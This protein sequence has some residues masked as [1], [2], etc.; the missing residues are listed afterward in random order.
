MPKAAKSD[1]ENENFRRARHLSKVKPI[2]AE[3]LREPPLYVKNKSQNNI[4]SAA[5]ERGLEYESFVLDW[6]EESYGESFLPSPWFRYMELDHIVRY[7][8]PDGILLDLRA[9]RIVL[10][11]IKLQHVDKAYFQLVNLYLPLAK[12]IF[13]PSIWSFSVIEICEWL[14]GVSYF[15]V[16]ILEA[17]SPAEASPFDFNVMRLHRQRYRLAGQTPRRLRAEE[18]TTLMSAR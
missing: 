2:A 18:L 6:L 9:G 17:R 7:A 4:R 10:V 5:S 8:Q 15:P 12:K 14:D 3:L 1:P 13:D 11:E 16:P